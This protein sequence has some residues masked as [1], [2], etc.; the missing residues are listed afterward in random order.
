MTL[1]IND[2]M[3]SC[4]DEMTMNIN[5]IDYVILLDLKVIISLSNYFYTYIHEINIITLMIKIT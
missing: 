2:E 1:I 5:C 3:R 4:L